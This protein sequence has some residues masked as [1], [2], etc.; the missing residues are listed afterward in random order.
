ME[1]LKKKTE[2]K[3]EGEVLRGRRKT[4]GWVRIELRTTKV[5]GIGPSRQCLRQQSIGVQGNPLT[6]KLG[7]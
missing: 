3:G 7:A 4:R 2:R 5:K 1:A 6:S